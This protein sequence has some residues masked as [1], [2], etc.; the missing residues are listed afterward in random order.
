MSA[1]F[2]SLFSKNSPFPGYHTFSPFC[3][4]SSLTSLSA[5][6]I[7]E[8]GNNPIAY[9]CMDMICSSVA[10]LYIVLERFNQCGRYRL[11]CK[12]PIIDVMA[13]PNMYMSGHEFLYGITKSLMEYGNAFVRVVRDSDGVPTELYSLPANQVEI[14]FNKRNYP[15]SYKYQAGG[16]T[17]VF[18]IHPISGQCDITH[19]KNGSSSNIFLGQGALQIAAP[20]IRQYNAISEWNHSYIE[21]GAKPSGMLIMEGGKNLSE[22]QYQRVKHQIETSFTGASNAGRPMLLEGGLKWQEMKNASH[23]ETCYVENIRIQTRNIAIA[24]GVPPSLISTDEAK[25][26]NFLESKV[27]FLER[28]VLPIADNILGH[29]SRCFEGLFDDDLTITYDKSKIGEF[30]EQKYKLLE[31]IKNA[32][33]MTREEKRDLFNLDDYVKE[34]TSGTI[35]T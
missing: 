12:H 7:Q 20:A 27:A 1:F 33:F 31:Y 11:N 22:E 28:T 17:H 29:L 13:H 6:T 21:N 26:S 23:A 5:K 16:K 10:S 9:R 15:D 8:C 18:K 32:D 14:T 24:F 19:I 4:G 35:E 25:Y 2:K 30:S 34:S 3:G